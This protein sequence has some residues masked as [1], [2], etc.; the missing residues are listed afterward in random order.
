MWSKRF[1]SFACLDRDRQHSARE[2]HFYTMGEAAWCSGNLLGPREEIP[3][4][5]L[6]HT[7][8]LRAG[9]YSLSSLSLLICKMDGYGE[10]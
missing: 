6:L 1:L 2:G 7:N 3:T 5:A 9:H 10:D 4:P 8:W